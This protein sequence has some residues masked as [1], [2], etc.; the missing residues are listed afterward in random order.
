MNILVLEKKDYYRK[1]YFK[2]IKDFYTYILYKLEILTHYEIE[3]NSSYWVKSW[4][5]KLF[6]KKYIL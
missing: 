6:Y 4:Y 5:Y 2:R 1:S 3:N